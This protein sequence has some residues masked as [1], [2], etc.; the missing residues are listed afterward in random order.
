MRTR[1]TLSHQLYFLKTALVD[2]SEFCFRGGRWWHENFGAVFVY[3]DLPAVCA[4]A[5]ER[6]ARGPACFHK[7]TA[8]HNLLR[9]AVV[10][11]QYVTLSTFACAPVKRRRA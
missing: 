6:R 10:N 8:R 5:L 3:S 9:V 7:L 2:D 11:G 1:L 4:A